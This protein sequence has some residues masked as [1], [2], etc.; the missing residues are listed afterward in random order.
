MSNK[1]YDILKWVFTVGMPAITTLYL[2]LAMI[3]GWSYTEQIGATLT[4]ITT[5]ACALLGLSSVSYQKKLKG[6]K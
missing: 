1:V 4:A 5:C 2:T 6:G 3:W